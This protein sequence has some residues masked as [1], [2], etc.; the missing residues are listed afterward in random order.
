MGANADFLQ[1]A[2]VVRIAVVC[3]LG[4]GT[5]NVMVCLVT[6]H[7]VLR[8]LAYDPSQTWFQFEKGDTDFPCPSYHALKQAEYPLLFMVI[9]C[10]NSK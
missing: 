10:N 7:V 5:F 3:T 2:I 9:F 1:S 6:V 8:L 4:Y